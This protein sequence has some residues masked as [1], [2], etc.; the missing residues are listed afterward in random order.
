MRVLSV[1][2]GVGWVIT[3]S[4]SSLAWCCAA[5]CCLALRC[6]MLPYLIQGFAGATNCGKP[7][8]ESKEKI[9]EVKDFDCISQ[10][11]SGQKTLVCS[12]AK[13]YP[14]TAS[15]HKF[16]HV[17]C[18]FRKTLRKKT[19]GMLVARS[20]FTQASSVPAGECWKVICQLAKMT[21]SRLNSRIW[22]YV[23]TWQWRWAQY[24][25]SALVKIRPFLAK[26]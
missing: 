20:G 22:K 12:D 9:L 15:A 24:V 3:L 13:C 19:E 4:T 18:S 14:G 21:Q 2:G 11:H 1:W 16:M 5:T 25:G 17:A 10:L 7:P 6:N 26:I 8:V 23:R